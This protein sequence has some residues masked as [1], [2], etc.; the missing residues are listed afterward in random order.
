MYCVL[1]LG[2]V[3]MCFFVDS[4]WCMGRENFKWGRRGRFSIRVVTEVC[5]FWGGVVNN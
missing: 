5:V 3:V 1:I 2:F 4:V